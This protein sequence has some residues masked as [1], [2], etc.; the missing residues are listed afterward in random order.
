MTIS[1]SL[2]F[3]AVSDAS[4][5]PNDSAQQRLL[6][7]EAISNRPDLTDWSQMSDDIYRCGY[8]VVLRIQALP[9]KI[10]VTKRWEQCRIVG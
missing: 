5:P 4:S 9:W 7:A 10:Q 3:V 8:I 6:A 2:P 1:N